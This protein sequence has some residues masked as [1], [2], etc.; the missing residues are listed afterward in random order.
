MKKITI[1]VIGAGRIGKLHA[2]NLLAMPG[3]RLKSIA[4]PYL[5]PEEW[6][7]R[8]V[9][10]TLE[11]AEIFSDSEVE[12]VMIC[13]PTPTHAE[14]TEIAAMAGKHVFCEKPIALDPDRVRETLDVVEKT[15]VKLQ[16]GFNRRFDPTF[17]RVRKAVIDGEIGDVHLVKV[18]ARDPSPP[19]PE[20]VAESGGMF[21]DMTIHDFDMVRFLSGSEVEEV[22]AFGA[23]L[24]DPA[25]GEAG[26]VDTAVVT[27]KL[28]SGALAVIENSRKAVFG[29]D[30]RL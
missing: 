27:L 3:V 12:A 22:Q 15:G 13:S 11:P 5:E 29:Y 16:V 23:V 9:I 24:V 21:L 26:D 7:S 2:D 4:D 8:G 30:Q 17:A 25:I 6:S 18:I 19:P 1:G 28:T 14:F 10:P 20:Y